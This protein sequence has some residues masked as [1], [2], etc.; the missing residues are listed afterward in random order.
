MRRRDLEWLRR[1]RRRRWGRR[2]GVAAASTL[3]TAA[4]G[5]PPALGP[6]SETLCPG[7]W[8]PV[9]WP[10]LLLP[11][12]PRRCFHTGTPAAWEHQ[13]FK[14]QKK[15]AHVIAMSFHYFRFACTYVDALAHT[16]MK[17]WFWLQRTEH[18]RTLRCF[19]VL[20][21]EILNLVEESR[22]KATAMLSEHPCNVLP[23]ML[24]NRTPTIPPNTH[25]HTYVPVC[26]YCPLGWHKQ[27]KMKHK[28][29]HM[30]QLCSAKWE[31][32]ACDGR[33]RSERDCGVNWF[34]D[35]SEMG[36]TAKT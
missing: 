6:H 14:M 29:P 3:G 13:P 16:M 33:L 10:Q 34:K 19:G 17:G 2:P 31:S 35:T 9:W 27:I 1:G 11:A 22:W 8:S 24:Q 26:F 5:S 32:R 28:N 36:S 7:L 18:K 4:G 25:T 23:M 15:C 30:L 12:S 21:L 20:R